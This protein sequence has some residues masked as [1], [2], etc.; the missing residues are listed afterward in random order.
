[1]FYL[2]DFF[3]NYQLNLHLRKNKKNNKITIRQQIESTIHSL[4]INIFK[5]VEPE[6]P[7]GKWRWTSLMGPNKLT[8]LE[9]FPV[10]IFILG[11][12]GNEIQKLWHDFF[13]YNTMCKIDLTD[14]DIV[15][16]KFL[17]WQ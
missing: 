8:I 5:F 15:N 3:L 2:N 10:A 6:T 12:R 14:E 7:K 1:M 13:I 16:F 4:G 17:A 11:Q 9:K